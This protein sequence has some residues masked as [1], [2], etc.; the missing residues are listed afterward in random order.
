MIRSRRAITTLPEPDDLLVAHG[1]PDDRESLLADALARRDVIGR[2]V[3]ARVDLGA[4]HEFVD[5]DRMRALDLDLVE[6]VVVDEQVRILG[7]GVALGLVLVLDHVPGFGVDELPLHFVA[8]LA[9]DGV[10]RNARRGAGGGIEVDSAGDEGKLEIAFPVGSWGH[11]A[12]SEN[13]L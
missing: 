10:E 2:V 3:V 1:V 13:A 12:Y 7:D 9:I 5:V 11:G 4:G 8:G 6:L